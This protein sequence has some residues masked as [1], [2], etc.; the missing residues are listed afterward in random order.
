[1]PQIWGAPKTGEGLKV[2]THV[3]PVSPVS[4]GV[5]LAVEVA[6]LQATMEAAAARYRQLL[7]Q[8]CHQGGDNGD[9]RD[10]QTPTG[11]SGD[12]KGRGDSQGDTVTSVTA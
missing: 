11:T 5:T 10:S 4:P 8:K 9:S 1:M 7:Q 3:S 6:E 12:S 2:L